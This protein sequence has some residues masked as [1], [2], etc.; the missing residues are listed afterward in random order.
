MPLYYYK[1]GL[2]GKPKA[3]PYPDGEPNVATLG[4]QE[5]GAQA[6]ARVDG[7]LW[8]LEKDLYG[9]RRCF[10]V[11]GGVNTARAGLANLIGRHERSRLREAAVQ[12]LAHVV[13]A[14]A[15]TPMDIDEKVA[16]V[17]RSGATHVG[18]LQG[19]WRFDRTSTF[20]TKGSRV[21]VRGYVI[22]RLGLR[23]G[24]LPFC[25]LCV[26]FMLPFN[27]LDSLQGT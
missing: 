21:R 2:Q 12:A 24:L 22:D 20:G 13:I 25:C 1:H 8:R 7:V 17:V 18:R 6:G 4:S 16:C 26:S 5:R 10:G 14:N 9:T 3:S 11:C 19:F 23:L 27:Q 15:Q